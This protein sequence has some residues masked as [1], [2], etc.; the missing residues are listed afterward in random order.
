MILELPITNDPAQEFITQLG[1][2]KYRFEVKYN[3]VSGVWT[4]DISDPVT[5]T[6]LLAGVALVTG[7]SLLEAYNLALTNLVMIDEGL[8][9]ASTPPTPDDM[10]GRLKVYWFTDDELENAG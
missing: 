6:V 2:A 8:T 3:D 9:G 1:A 7:Q 5:N 10:G 4:M